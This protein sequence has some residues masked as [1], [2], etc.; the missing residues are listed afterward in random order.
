MKDGALLKMTK[1]EVN[2]AWGE[3]DPQCVGFL[4]FQDVWDWFEHHAHEVHRQVFLKSGGKRYFTFHFSDIVPAHEQALF[5]FKTRF[6]VQE[7]R[8]VSGEE[9]SDDESSEEETD[10]DSDEE[11]DEDDEDEEV[12]ELSEW[13]KAFEKLIEEHKPALLKNFAGEDPNA[14]NEDD[15]KIEKLK[16]KGSRKSKKEK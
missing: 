15:A 6:A 9:S 11:S 1:D 10:D 7:R 3:M 2:K 13:D 14:L 16:K 12:K 5:V 4:S 8:M